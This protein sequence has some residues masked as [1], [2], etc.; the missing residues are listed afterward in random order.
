MAAKRKPKVQSSDEIVRFGP[1]QKDKTLYL[2]HGLEFDGDP[3][4]LLSW[5]DTWEVVVPL[6]PYTELAASHGSVAE[7]K[8]TEKLVLD[9][10]QPVYD[11]RMVFV[12][13]CGQSQALLEAWEEEKAHC[14]CTKFCGLP[15]LRAL[16]RVKP[17]VLALPEVWT[18]MREESVT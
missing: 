7:R 8:L 18:Q 14:H 11:S 15:F 12:R 17:L 16:W 13:Q 4:P 5:L 2:S 6:R 10:R 1:G 3:E 9:L